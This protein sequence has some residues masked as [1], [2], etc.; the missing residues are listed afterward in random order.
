[1]GA[2]LTLPLALLLEKPLAIS[3]SLP[4]LGAWLGL[5]LLGT[6]I[7]Y[8]IYYAL[9]ERTSATFTSMVTYIIPINGLLLGAVILGEDLTMTVAISTA[10]ILA[11]VMLVQR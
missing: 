2:L 10:L 3:P 7:A 4:A 8:I 1:M 11:G 5:V 6:V 9:I